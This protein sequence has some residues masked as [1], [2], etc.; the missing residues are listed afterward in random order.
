MQRRLEHALSF[1][2]ITSALIAGAFVS[3]D[4]L[5]GVAEQ[6]APSERARP[7]TTYNVKAAATSALPA[8]AA[9]HG[10]TGAGVLIAQ[11]DEGSVRA[12]HFELS[13]RVRVRD[14]A[15]RSAISSAADPSAHATHI[16][17][18]LIGDGTL[19]P[20]AAGVA[21]GAALW[22]H[23]WSWDV[24]EE[25]AA[26][27]FVAVSTHAYGVALGWAGRGEGCEQGATFFGGT[28]YEDAAFGKYWRTA[29]QLDAALFATD[30]ISIWAAGN[31]RADA[32]P[33]GDAPHFHYP[34]CEQPHEDLHA[35]EVNAHYDTLGGALS[36]KNAIAVGAAADIEIEPITPELIVPLAFSSFGPTDDGRIKPDLV[37]SGETLYS[38]SASSDTEHEVVSGT[39]SAASVV[40]G[41]VALLTQIYRETHDGRDPRAAE[42]KALLLHTARE[43][44]GDEG[45]D[46]AMGF[47]L[48]DGVAAANVLQEDGA[49]IASAEPARLIEV[50]VLHDGQAVELNAAELAPGTALRVTLAWIDPAGDANEGGIDQAT[51]ALRNDLELALIA[52]DGVT[53]FYPWRL[54]PEQPQAAASRDGPNHVDPIER[55]DVP[56][57]DNVWQGAWTVRVSSANALLGDRPQAFALVA[58]APLALPDMPVLA[59]TRRV[60]VS[61]PEGAS[62]IELPIAIENAGGGTLEWSLTLGRAQDAA[63]LS[64]SEQTGVAPAAPIVRID[65]VLM[66]NAREV[67]ATV[68]LTSNEA[69]ATRDIG[70]VLQRSCESGC[71]LECA[72]AT[73]DRGAQCGAVDLGSVL[74]RLVSGRTEL[75]VAAQRASC[76]GGALPEAAFSW[77]APEAGTFEV[78]LESASG[79][80]LL[81]ALDDS[82]DAQC[83]GAELACANGDAGQRLSLALDAGQGAVLV[84]AAPIGDGFELAIERAREVDACVGDCDPA[85]AGC[86]PAGCAD[87]QRCRSGRCEPDPCFGIGDGERCDDADP[88]TQTDICIGGECA[89]HALAC[90]CKAGRCVEQADG[91]LDASV[92]QSDGAVE[93][94]A[95]DEQVDSGVHAAR[96]RPTDCGCRIARA[97]ARSDLS[98]AFGT[99][100]CALCWLVARRARR[101]ARALI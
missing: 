64:L 15:W 20:S 40:A 100:A 38:T 91:G 96:A 76:A 25:R 93:A 85:P 98:V 50:A 27:P 19:E 55:V 11:W 90:A 46:Y 43:A 67:L 31:E 12:S 37:A 16:A 101:L 34:D 17:G 72:G 5:S 22:S 7:L 61:V 6:R 21:Q 10:A 54:D 68:R 84:V 4:Q 88:C 42:M 69:T 99:L 62:S 36:A 49:L 89:G 87:G 57:E 24:I 65:P 70:I 23:T 73:C 33:F 79:D 95:I 44:G 94:G 60:L 14:R 2:V 18:T 56:A 3:R 8:V 63:W 9:Q 41:G 29:A 58:S 35:H 75:P 59:S 45:P 30:A 32:G 86:G 28:G 47:G 78:A 48:F 13:G 1:A 71:A 26:A 82:L 74:G 97:H 66:P 53:I 39:S 51:P 80:A 83:D 77:R 81:Y 92:V 52:P